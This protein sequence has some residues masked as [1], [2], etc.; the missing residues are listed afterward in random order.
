M[1]HL[2]NVS[3]EIE[4]R[5]IFNNLSYDFTNKKY[6]LVG[7]NGIGKTTLVNLLCG[8]LT[9]TS[10]NVKSLCQVGLF[11]QSAILQPMSVGDYLSDVWN[12][13]HYQ[14]LIK[15]LLEFIPFERSL[16]DLS[17]GELMSVRLAKLLSGEVQF[18]I[19]DE[20]TNNLDESRKKIV[21]KIIDEFQGGMLI[22]SHD[23][24]L[25]QKVDVILELSNQGISEYGGNFDFYFDERTT[26]REKAKEKL[27]RLKRSEKQVKKTKEEKL[28]KQKKRMKEASKQDGLPRILIG[29]RKSRAQETLGRIDFSE[30]EAVQE[31]KG[32]FKEKWGQIKFDPFVKFDFESTKP[33]QGKI[34]F[35]AKN[36]NFKFR[37]CEHQLWRVSL[38]FVVR[39][40]EKYLLKGANGS[41]K[42]T[43]I[44]L[45]FDHNV[46]GGFLE[47]EI[48]R[49]TSSVAYLDQN[50]GSLISHLS[51]LDNLLGNSRFNMVELRNE[52]ALLGFVG[53][54]V[55]Q[56]VES[57]SG[58]EL[59]KAC[60]AK[61]FL[62]PCIPD[63]IILDEPTNNL[64]IFSQELLVKSLQKFKGAIMLV[65]HDHFFIEQMGITDELYLERR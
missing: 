57:L 17:G 55:H 11:K 7:P 10:G 56:K 62:G 37:N 23:R 20:P 48:Y 49:G 27:D 24:S 61:T 65:C 53:E 63:I 40:Q 59:L 39:G 21:G 12:S 38:S 14:K 13:H 19:L 52:L 45:L 28:Q 51:L 36:L 5:S 41:G 29:K 30:S 3:Y 15:S 32:K 2:K 43:L 4:S 18:I 35:S 26:E 8:F 42:T 50:Y 31:A 1:L 33:P 25:L 44:K 60:L 16:L 54:S 22:I 9:P 34:H 6:G 46:P 64:D 58:G 47:G